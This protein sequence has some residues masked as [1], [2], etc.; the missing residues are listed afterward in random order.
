MKRTN[1]LSPEEQRRIKLLSRELDQLEVVD[2]M[3]N[4][5][6]QPDEVNHVYTQLISR[7]SRLT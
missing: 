7:V 2:E 4:F 5:G 1:E 6:S 3:I